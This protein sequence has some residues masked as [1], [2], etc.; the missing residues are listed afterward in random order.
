MTMENTTREN[1]ISG[2][3]SG[4]CGRRPSAALIEK[5]I[6]C[7]FYIRERKYRGR[8]I[9]N[10]EGGRIELPD[11]ETRRTMVYRSCAHPDGWKN[12]PVAVALFDYY[13]RR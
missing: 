5:S 11:N 1:T 6:Y 7:P 4:D 3:T 13:D 8:Y 10:C 2:N 12:C 9:L